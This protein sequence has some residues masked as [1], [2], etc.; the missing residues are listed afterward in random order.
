MPTT[1][2]KHSQ[3]HAADLAATNNLM[4]HAKQRDGEAKLAEK[5]TKTAEFVVNEAEKKLSITTKKSK[6]KKT[7]DIAVAVAVVG[8]KEST[9]EAKE[10]WGVAPKKGFCKFCSSHCRLHKVCCGGGG[11]GGNSNFFFDCCGQF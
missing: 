3:N 11:P 6:Q 9:I 2:S 8:V 1:R 4:A 7:D 10:K 5:E